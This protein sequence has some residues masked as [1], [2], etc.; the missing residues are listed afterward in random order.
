[1]SDVTIIGLDLAKRVLQ[2]HGAWADGS[3]AFPQEAD[4]CAAAVVLG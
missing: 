2:L 4:T 3:V 1:M